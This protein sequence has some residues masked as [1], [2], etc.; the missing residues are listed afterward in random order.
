MRK[1]L[2]LMAI[3]AAFGLTVWIGVVALAQG[4]SAPT[5]SNSTTTSSAATSVEDVEG[6]CDEAEHANDPECVGV[7]PVAEDDHE[8]DQGDVNDDD[9]GENNDNDDHGDVNDDDQGE[10]NDDQGE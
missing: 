2:R 7:N 5:P 6:N 10:N 9:Q 4:S 3:L 1:A 8:N